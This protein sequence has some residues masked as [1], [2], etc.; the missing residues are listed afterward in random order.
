V[1]DIV[2]QALLLKRDQIE[3]AKTR[4]IVQ[5]LYNKEKAP[6]ALDEYR[7]I[8][9]PY[10]QRSQRKE[11][12]RYIAQLTKEIQRGIMQVTPLTRPKARSKLRT[13]VVER[14]A[15]EQAAAVR[16]LSKRLG[17]YQDG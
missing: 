11:R 12:D 5:A 8:Q 17:G 7:D 10:Y 16:R 15:D 4:A 1:Q 13:R 9:F 14:S 2:L 6:E 3:Y